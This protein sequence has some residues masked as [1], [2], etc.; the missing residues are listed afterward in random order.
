M[1]F[2]T[3]TPCDKDLSNRLI[4]RLILIDLGCSMVTL[5]TEVGRLTNTK[6][7]EVSKPSG[8]AKYYFPFVPSWFCVTDIKYNRT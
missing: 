6:D 8:T 5:K 7:F 2:I 4:L 1:N 3:K